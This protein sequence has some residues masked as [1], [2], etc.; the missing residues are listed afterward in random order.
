[1]YDMEY[2]PYRHVLPYDMLLVTMHVLLYSSL[3]F[4]SPMTN[5]GLSVNWEQ[6]R[7]KEW[8]AFHQQLFCELMT[9]S[10]YDQNRPALPFETCYW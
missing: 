10:K 2:D 7:R 3:I 9:W 1:M 8:L 5:D 6:A 4:T